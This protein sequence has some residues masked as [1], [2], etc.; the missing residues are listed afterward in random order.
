MKKVRECELGKL[1]IVDALVM[2]SFLNHKQ[3]PSIRRL[4]AVTPPALM[5]S[6]RKITHR[7]LFPPLLHLHS[8]L[9]IPLW[10]ISLP[11]VRSIVV[12]RLLARE[13]GLLLLD[14]LFLLRADHSQH[15]GQ[16][17]PPCLESAC[18]FAP[19]VLAQQ[20][21]VDRVAVRHLSCRGRLSIGRVTVMMMKLVR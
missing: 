6:C 18:N 19:L 14:V 8:L 4:D 17:T 13:L 11:S 7:Q 2:E 9:L 15:I 12:T 20:I 16:A 5:H 3:A 10:R 21:H 1:V